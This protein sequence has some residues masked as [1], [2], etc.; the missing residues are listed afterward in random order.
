MKVDLY[1]QK[2]EKIGKIEAKD[3][4]FKVKV[5]PELLHEAVLYYENLSR[6]GTAKTKDRSEVSGGGRKPWRQK[7]TGRARHGSIRSPIWRKGGV[8]FGPTPEKKYE[9][10]INKKAKRKSLFGVLTAK[11]N[12]N[13][14]FFIDKI[15]IKN[16][17][18]K[19]VVNLI[20]NLA[21]II[22]DIKKKKTIFILEKKDENFLKAVS[23]IKNLLTIPA[24]SLNPYFLLKAKYVLIE[25]GA[26]KVLEN[27][28]LKEGKKE[29]SK[30][31]KKEK[32]VKKEKKEKSQLVSE[33]KTKN[34]KAEK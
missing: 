6:R 10:K 32:K 17:K 21:K 18:T 29:K 23:N 13:E 8:V 9:V 28:Y 25:K 15:E 7:G 34:K 27:H 22:K 33:S 19:E 5:K 16:P 12:D 1:N 26:L 3:E 14:I 2:G 4:I 11:L 24:D 31:E 20:E 30:E